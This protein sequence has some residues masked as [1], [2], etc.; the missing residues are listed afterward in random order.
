MANGFFDQPIPGSQN[1]G[2]PNQGGFFGGAVQNPLGLD[3][4]G[5]NNPLPTLDQG[6]Q[7]FQGLGD[8]GGGFFDRL[9][10]LSGTFGNISK[11]VGGLAQAWTGLQNLKLAR[12]AY[13][14]QNRQWQANFDRQKAVSDANVANQNAR[15]RAIGSG[16]RYQG[17]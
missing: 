3:Q 15:S 2:V 11:G 1:T 9:G 14:D 17:I 4:S 7:G 5:L 8:Q 6:V 10:S 12:Q 16:V 13:D